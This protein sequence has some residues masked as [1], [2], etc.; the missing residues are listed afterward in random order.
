MRAAERTY[1]QN[2]L[3]A[4]K[5]N[6][7]KSWKIIKDIINKNSKKSQKLPKITINGQLCENPQNIAEAFNKY[8]ANIGSTLD[9]KIPHSNEYPLKFIKSNHT[10]NLFLEPTTTS[11]IDK[12][13]DKLKNCAVGWD[14]LP[15][16]IFKENK[17]PLSGILNH[18]MNLSLEQGTFPNEL[19]KANIIPIFKAGETD[20]IG[21]YRPVSLL[22]TVSKVFE[23]A[24][25]NRLISFIT[26]QKILYSLQ[27][28]F[29]EGHGT[30]MAIL[31]FL[32]N[33]IDSLD[34]GD[35]AATI[36][37]DFS[38]AFD[39]VNHHILLQKLSHYGIRGTANKWFESYL[40]N[41]SQFCTF[42]G[43]Q[44]DEA[45]ISC[46][47]PQGSILGPLLFLIYINDL[48]TIFQNL[49]TVLFADDSNLIAS[50]NSIETLER[51]INQDIPL[52][53]KW[54]QTNR[55]SLNIKKTHVMVFGRKSKNQTND[56]SVT[57]EGTKLEIV[58]HTKFLGV[59]LDNEINWKQHILH[60][61]QKLSKSLGILKRARQFLNTSTLLQLYYSFLYPYLS[62]CCI[63]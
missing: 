62:Y 44:S 36:F 41:R 9:R 40:S 29:R 10:I 56:L 6:M 61:S 18:I 50:G 48:G 30:H 25:Y 45:I 49:S 46:G 35:Y 55:L 24:M 4:C 8:F 51:K 54:L 43:K 5:G 16:F 38:K 32:D 20:I 12:I 27:F 60:I 34:R 31:K 52:L 39:T 53:T 63:I 26:Q 13:I 21:N 7:R 58:K 28:G 22:T 19:K 47:V 3:L 17:D 59:I 57:I 1:Y 11:E 15:A 33:I 23:R 14:Q 2:E 37:L 42:G